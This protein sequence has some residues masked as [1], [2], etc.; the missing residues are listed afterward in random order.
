MD[1]IGAGDAHIGT[2]LALLTRDVPL[3]QAI[4]CA[5]EAAGAVVGIQGASLPAEKVPES[6]KKYCL[7]GL[8]TCYQQT[9]DRNMQR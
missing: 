9:G 3:G 7:E 2:I 1:T 8:E 6:L 4:A 5:N